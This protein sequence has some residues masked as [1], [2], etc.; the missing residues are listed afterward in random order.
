MSRRRHGRGG[1]GAPGGVPPVYEGPEVLTSL[2]AQAGSPHRAEEVADRFAAAQANGEPRS[3]VIPT[4]FPEEPRFP[5]P[6]AARRLYGNLFGLWARLEA[7]LGA[8][9]DAPE[10]VPTPSPRPPLPERGSLRGSRLT[11]EVVEAV[12]THLA[13]ESPRRQRARRDRYVHAQPD[14]VAWLDAFPLPE[15]GAVAAADLCFEAWAMFDQAF[16]DRLRTVDWK[17][18]RALEPE[19]PT[20]EASQP[21]LAGYLAEQLDTLA[22]E[23]PAFGASERAQVERAVAVVA[24][25]LGAAVLEPS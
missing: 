8:H 19:P 6:E 1:S 10:V 25:A 16:G 17:E 12:W 18:L 24:A 4:L 22:D 7:G 3:D 20:V 23:D 14:L 11:P 2:L 21:A 5:S 13:D 15:P 9:D